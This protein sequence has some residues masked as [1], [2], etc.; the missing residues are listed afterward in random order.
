SSC[1]GQVIW[2]EVVTSKVDVLVLLHNSR[3]LIPNFLK[4]L[5]KITIPVTVFF[6]DNNSRDGSAELVSELLP[7]LPFK[8][9]LLRS[10]WNN[11]FAG[12]MNRLACL[13]QSEFIFLLK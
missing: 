1:C 7:S 8:A 9:H 3:A 12:G 5:R 2:K 4:S 11:G 13:S 10:R 6:L